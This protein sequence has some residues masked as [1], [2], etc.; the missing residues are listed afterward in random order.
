MR[1]WTVSSLVRIL[2]WTN[3]YLMSTGSL[4]NKLGCKIWVKISKLYF[5]N[6]YRERSPHSIEITSMHVLHLDMTN[7]RYDCN[8]TVINSS[9]P[10][11]NGRHL[12][13]E[14]FK[15]E[16]FCISIRIS[17]KFVPMGPI[18]NKWALVQVMAWRRTGNKPISEPM[19]TQFTGT[20]MLH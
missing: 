13:D 17:L 11:Q 7:W 14:I 4:S 18:D 20:Y 3:V 5:K 10:G 19:L 1:H 9:P 8:S 2:V 15:W 12:A 16:N 6:M